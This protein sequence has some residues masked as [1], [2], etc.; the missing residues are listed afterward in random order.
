MSRF[1]VIFNKDLRLARTEGIFLLILLWSPIAVAVARWVVHL[2]GADFA[3]WGPGLLPMWLTFMMIFIGLMLLAPLFIYEKENNTWP[4]LRLTPITLLELISAKMVVGLLCILVSAA[5]LILI[6]IGFDN[7]LPLLVIT[8]FGS[9]F[10][11]LVG[12]LVSH[13]GKTMMQFMIGVRLVLIPL[14]LPAILYVIPGVEVGWF[15]IIPTYF[16]LRATEQ[17]AVHGA[18]LGDVAVDMAI[19]AAVSVVLL[20]VNLKIIARRER[21]SF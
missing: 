18:S 3:Y 7:I 13:F 17:V 4:A 8:L 15:R 20:V 2:I 12:L 5:L 11:L 19:L 10:T 21:R 16:I 6:S 9:L 14:M 1:L